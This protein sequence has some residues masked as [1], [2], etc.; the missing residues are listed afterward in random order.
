MTTR[1]RTAL[2]QNF[3]HAMRKP[4]PEA[5]GEGQ[6]LLTC[7]VE[8][9]QVISDP[10]LP[11]WMD[12]TQQ[13]QQTIHNITFFLKD[14]QRAQGQHL[15]VGFDDAEEIEKRV[16]HLT[17]ELA[18][19]FKFCDSQIR[20]IPR[21]TGNDRVVVKNCQTQLI[22]ELTKLCSQF[23]KNQQAYLSKLRGQEHQLDTNIANIEDDEEV[24]HWGFTSSQATLVAVNEDLLRA[25]EAEIAQITQS[26]MD[27][28]EL[29]KDLHCMFMFHFLSLMC[30]DF[31]FDFS[32]G[33]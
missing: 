4:T 11:P 22:T 9:P 25:R 31:L 29:F 28:A 3:R 5:G 33:H 7:D 6:T 16:D 13:V 20:A 19:M 26:V 23:K 2:F 24:A 18:R 12:M 10:S 8:R 30:F 14:L 21:D 1:N 15:L 17:R 32:I 27:L